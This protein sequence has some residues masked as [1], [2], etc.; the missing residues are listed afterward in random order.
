MRFLNTRRHRTITCWRICSTIRAVCVPFLIASGANVF[1]NEL[2]TIIGTTATHSDNITLVTEGPEDSEVVLEPFVRIDYQL[3]F[4]DFDAD[5][6]YS[7]KVT[8]FRQNSFDDREEI[9]GEGSARWNLIDRRLFLDFY[10]TSQRLSVDSAD[11]DTPANQ[12]R[13][14]VY[15]VA[16]TFQMN[17]GAASFM[18]VRATAT[19][20]TFERDVVSGSEQQGVTLSLGSRVLG[21]RQVGVRLEYTE[22][23]FDFGRPGFDNQRLVFSIGASGEQFSYS[24]A[25]GPD[26]LKRESGETSGSFLAASASLERT[27]DE[28]RVS[29]TRQ[30][31]DTSAGLSLSDVP[32]SA[33]SN[34]DGNFRIADTVE[35]QR[36]ELNYSLNLLPGKLKV[37]ARLSNDEEDYSVVDEDQSVRSGDLGFEYRFSPRLVTSLNTRWNQREL[38][39]DSS[40]IVNRQLELGLRYNVN[41]RLSW[42]F[43]VRDK[44]RNSSREGATADEL[45]TLLG[46]D[47]WL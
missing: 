24:L 15:S 41:T 25:L 40:N 21:S 45:E 7:A 47:Y 14:D 22:T 32:E 43:S 6:S 31:T 20:A 36:A 19:E 9:T 2:R 4:S 34:G 26:R 39:F 46:F 12:T 35:R 38:D 13:R 44:S 42:R 30:L 28:L 10:Q 29:F 11:I 5:L 3:G 23:E 1:G 8:D 16:P 27:N 37:S 33:L 17:F 18:Q